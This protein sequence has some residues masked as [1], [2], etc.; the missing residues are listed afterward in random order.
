MPFRPH[1]VMNNSPLP[2]NIL[3]SVKD[4]LPR[5]LTNVQPH[6]DRVRGSRE[7]SPTRNGSKAVQKRS[8]DV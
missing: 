6:W 2:H 1:E 5:K 7:V 4:E 8:E 3:D